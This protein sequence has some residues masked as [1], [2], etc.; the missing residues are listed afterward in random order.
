MIGGKANARRLRAQISADMEVGFEG[1]HW[2]MI[3]CI[4]PAMYL[5]IVSIARMDILVEEVR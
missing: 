5:A 1:L 2:R 3:G 4:P